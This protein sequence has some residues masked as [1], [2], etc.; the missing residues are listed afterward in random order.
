MASGDQVYLG[1]RAANLRSACTP[2]VWSPD[3]R[4]V[5][6]NTGD[7]GLALPDP[8][9]WRY[10][11]SDGSLSSLPVEP[12]NAIVYAPHIAGDTLYALIASGDITN[13][14]YAP[15]APEPVLSYTLS[16]VP[17]TGGT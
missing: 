4:T 9:I 13:P 16:S 11:M 10:D 5:V 3:G 1:D 6:F 14:V 2:A 8:G 17:L 15:A 7:P 12:D